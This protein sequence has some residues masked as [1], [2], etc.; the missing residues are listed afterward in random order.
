M[1]PL[2]HPVEVNA[3]IVEHLTANRARPDFHLPGGVRIQR[4]GL[5]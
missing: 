1:S 5:R 4:A 2:T 3:L